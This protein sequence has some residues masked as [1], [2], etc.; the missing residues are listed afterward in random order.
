[1]SALRYATGAV[2]H[3]TAADAKDFFPTPPWATRAVLPWIERTSGVI[4]EPACG[5]MDMAKPLIEHFGA[6]S[7]FSSDVCDYGG[8]H[9]DR[10]DFLLTMPAQLPH[11][12]VEWII[13][14]PPFSLGG[15][16]IRHAR[17]V[18]GAKVAMLVRTQFLEG[19]DRYYNTFAADPPS[20]VLQFV[21]RVPMVHGRL[22]RTQSTATSYCWL[23]WGHHEQDHARPTVLEW[24]PPCRRLLERHGDYWDDAERL[25]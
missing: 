24:I 19:K 1:M 11:L 22:S 21:E 23:L 4:W 10:R 5:G 2:R 12:D 14:N 7:V 15:D 9:D 20:R 25:I 18:W 8:G 17:D 6:G 3:T 13:T 16:F